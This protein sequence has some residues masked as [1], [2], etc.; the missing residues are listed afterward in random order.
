[1]FCVQEG[2]ILRGDLSVGG[3]VEAQEEVQEQGG[4]EGG[5]EGAEE[6]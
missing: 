5:E 4:E 6:E 1:M 2:K 3:L